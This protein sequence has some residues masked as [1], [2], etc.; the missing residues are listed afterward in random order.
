MNRFIIIAALGLLLA[1]GVVHAAGAAWAE[2]LRIV[3]P[4]AGR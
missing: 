4:L 2:Y 3:A 1:G